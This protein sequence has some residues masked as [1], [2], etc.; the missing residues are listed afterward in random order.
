MTY[1]NVRVINKVF[2]MLVLLNTIQSKSYYYTT[3]KEKVAGSTFALMQLCHIIGHHWIR[4]R[5]GEKKR[6]KG[7]YMGDLEEE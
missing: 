5:K 4:E 7:W 6:G 3:A 2:E 1:R